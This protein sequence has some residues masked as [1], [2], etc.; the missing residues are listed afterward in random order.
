MSDPEAP[1]FKSQFIPKNSNGETLN[2]VGV[3]GITPLKNGRYL[4][5]IT[6]GSN[7]SWFFY[8][9]NVSDLSSEDLSWQQVRTPLGPV[10][11]DAHQTLNFLREGSIDGDLVYRG[12]SGARRLCSIFTNKIDLYKIEWRYQE[13]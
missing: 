11:E 1:V 9:S 10:T 5:V 4:M 8:R 3:V 13:F 2:G 7:H 12:R 6:G